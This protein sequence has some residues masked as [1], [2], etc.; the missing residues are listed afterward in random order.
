MK[1]F[2]QFS[3]FQ[4]FMTLA[5]ILAIE[6]YTIVNSFLIFDFLK[7]NN[8]KIMNQQKAWLLPVKSNSGLLLSEI[9]KLVASLEYSGKEVTKQFRY[10]NSLNIS[11]SAKP[12]EKSLRKYY[13]AQFKLVQVWEEL[14]ERAVRLR[15]DFT[16]NRTKGLELKEIHFGYYTLLTETR[17]FN[18]MH[19][20][21]KKRYLKYT[22]VFYEEAV[23]TGLRA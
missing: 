10:L 22:P 8:L 21:L 14:K 13:S 7:P 12:E 19:F 1:I 5:R 17:L 4:H 6:K 16:H 15:T 20:Q 11:K 18:E 9:N 3:H 23:F 2:S